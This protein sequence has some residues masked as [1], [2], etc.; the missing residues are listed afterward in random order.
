[1]QYRKRPV[2]IDAIQYQ[3]EK[4]IIAVQDF[5]GDGNGRE[6]LFDSDKN[7]YF[8]KTLEGYMYLRRGDWIIKGIK[9][10]LYPCKNDIFKATYEKVSE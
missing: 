4:N 6:L 8:I 7:E 3:R 5:F 10:E 2:I 9:G 1:M